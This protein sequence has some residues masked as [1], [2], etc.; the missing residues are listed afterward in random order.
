MMKREELEAEL[1]APKWKTGRPE[2]EG[3]YLVLDIYGRNWLMYYY[4]LGGWESFDNGIIAWCEKPKLD[5]E[6]KKETK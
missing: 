1:E 6:V 4:G 2:K 3:E 5:I